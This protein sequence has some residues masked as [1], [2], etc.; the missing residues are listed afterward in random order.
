M[1]IQTK[2]QLLRQTSWLTTSRDV[3]LWIVAAVITFLEGEIKFYCHHALSQLIIITLKLLKHVSNNHRKPTEKKM[4]CLY[5]DLF[6][7]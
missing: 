7:I 2:V 4:T 5:I 6:I 3:L 1:H